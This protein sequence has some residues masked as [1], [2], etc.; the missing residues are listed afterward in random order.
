[1]LPSFETHHMYVCMYV[2]R[3]CFGVCSLVR[4]CPAR[5]CLACCCP[6]R[7]FLARY[8]SARAVQLGPVQPVAVQPGPVQPGAIQP[9]P[10]QPVAV[11]SGP[12][13]PDA[14]FSIALYL[15]FIALVLRSY[16]LTKLLANWLTYSLANLLM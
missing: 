10:V 3:L 5:S 15:S 4:P 6:A 8:F 7:S 14:C 2:F 12:A 11:H 9:Y 16:A 13:M 1:M